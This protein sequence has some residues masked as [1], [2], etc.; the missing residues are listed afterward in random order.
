MGLPEPGLIEV[1]T[2]SLWVALF[3][4]LAPLP[5]QWTGDEAPM[6]GTLRGR[7]SRPCPG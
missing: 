7:G 4:V 6:A 2:P 1:L 5:W 3:L